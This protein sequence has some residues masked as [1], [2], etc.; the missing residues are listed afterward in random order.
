MKLILWSPIWM[1]CK[2]VGREILVYRETFMLYIISSVVCS[3]NLTYLDLAVSFDTSKLLNN[4]L[5][6]TSRVVLILPFILQDLNSSILYRIK[7]T[8]SCAILSGRYSTYLRPMF[9]LYAPWK[10]QKTTG[11]LTFPGGI[12]MEHWPKMG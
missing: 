3:L 8:S 12:E 11:F 2:K 10:P 4:C 5:S 7:L 9:H 6:Y 1:V